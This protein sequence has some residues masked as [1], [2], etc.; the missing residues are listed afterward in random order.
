MCVNSGWTSLASVV[1]SALL[2]RWNMEIVVSN[3]LD[4]RMLRNIAT[5]LHAMRVEGDVVS[6][7][8]FGRFVAQGTRSRIGSEMH[9]RAKAARYTNYDGFEQ[10]RSI[11]PLS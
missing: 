1:L 6:V 9:S 4:T 3:A 10:S 7:T 11:T 5:E 2:T 8:H